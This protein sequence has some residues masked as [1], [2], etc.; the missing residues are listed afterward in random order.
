[1]IPAV[2]DRTMRK[3]T[4]QRTTMLPSAMDNRRLATGLG[5]ALGCLLFVAPP[6]C[7]AQNLVPNHSF[8]EYDTCRVV[9]DVYFPDNGPLGWF[10]AA[11]TPDHFM[12]CLPYATFNSV[13]MNAIA[14]QYP[15]DGECY[16]GV[17]TYRAIPP[18]IR[19]YFMV[20]LVEPLVIGQQY[21][22]S[23]YAG[24]GWGGYSMNPPAWLYTNAIGMLFTMQ[25]R[26]WVLNDPYPMPLNVA[27]VFSQAMITDTVGWALVSGSFVADSA[28]QYLLMG[29]H[30]DNAS[31]DTMQIV[32]HPTG[33]QIG[34]V[35]FDNVC[36]S[37]D[38]KGCP[39]AVGIEAHEADGPRLFPNPASDWIA[40]QGIVSGTGITIHDAVGRV[41]WHGAGS[42]EYFHLEVGHWARGAYVLHAVHA[43]QQR[44][45]K[46]V[47]IE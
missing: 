37:V 42:G 32:Y 7:E 33:A 10:S 30:F 39:M 6:C 26:Q 34:Y 43:G 8:E 19:E 3:M 44:S 2:F 15:Q 18:N 16:A 46:F 36:V 28:Y 25:P 38:P 35:L 45:F 29:N 22:A 13:P 14:F 40:L 41:L 1:M 9:N 31:T 20:Q 47:L 27:H 4:Q 24:V 11:G 5:L 17:V 23:F 21:Y 12:S